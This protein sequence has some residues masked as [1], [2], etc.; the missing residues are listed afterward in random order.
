[1]SDV[2]APY[3]PGPPVRVVPA[4]E[5]ADWPF[6]DTRFLGNALALLVGDLPVWREDGGQVHGAT[7]LAHFN[8]LLGCRPGADGS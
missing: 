4:A 5:L 6:D 1:M 7:G 2:P 3:S 8:Q